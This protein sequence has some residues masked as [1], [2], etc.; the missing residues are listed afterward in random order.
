MGE[1]RENYIDEIVQKILSD[2]DG[3]K[4]IDAFNIYND[5]G[6]ITPV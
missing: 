5:V 2:Y 3:D 6:V 1:N 4:N